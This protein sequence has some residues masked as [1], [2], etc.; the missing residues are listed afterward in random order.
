MTQRSRRM[1]DLGYQPGQAWLK[2]GPLNS[3]TDVPGVCVGVKTLRS[4]GEG[5]INSYIGEPVIRTGVTSILPRP[6]YGVL[7][8]PVFASIFQLNGTGEMTSSHIIQETGILHSP[9]VLGGTT[10]LGAMIEGVARWSSYTSDEDEEGRPLPP[11]VLPCVA[12]TSDTLSDQKAFPVK[13]DHVREALR[14]SAEKQ[15][16]AH[17]EGS[18]GGGTGM[19][20]QGFKG[21]N[22]TSSRLLPSQDGKQYTLGAFVQA[23]FGT[24]RDFVINGLPI[25]KSLIASGFH[26]EKKRQAEA[27]HNNTQPWDNRKDGSIIVV[28]ATDMPLVPHQLSRLCRRVPFGLAHVGAIAHSFSGDIFLAFST[29]STVPP[30]SPLKSD[31]TKVGPIGIPAVGIES[32]EQV[33]QASL[34]V[35]FYAVADVV[36]EAVLNALCAAE[37]ETGA[38]GTS[39]KGLPHDQVQDILTNAKQALS[40]VFPGLY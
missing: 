29:Q 5:A 10:S 4:G 30:N 2:P 18:H 33:T 7:Y 20:C 22:G 9:I 17:F 34:N 8:D 19:M 24:A 6:Q 26:G 23:N 25:G 28:L 31:S 3:I 39:A 14:D 38:N 36:E 37:D 15:S 12:E 40:G 1:R 27:D 32:V 13:V 11:F 16:P 35:I 21:G